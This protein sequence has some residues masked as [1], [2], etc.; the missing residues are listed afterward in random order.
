[1][2]MGEFSTDSQSVCEL[3]ILQ[4][5]EELEQK[6]QTKENLRPKDF[7]PLLLLPLHVDKKYLD[8]PF[9]ND[10][11]TFRYLNSNKS[12]VLF[13]MRGIPGS[14]KSTIVNLIKA[15]FE[16][17]NLVVCSAD[18]FF[19]K[20]DGSYTFNERLLSAAH[21]SCQQKA[22][23]ACE[24]NTPVVV[25]DNT[26]IRGW[27]MRFYLN[28]STTFGYVTVLVQ[29]KTPW[30]MDPVELAA[31]NSHSV[32]LEAIQRKVKSFEDVVPS[33][34]AWFCNEEKSMS[35]LRLSSQLLR[36]CLRA[37]PEFG[38]ELLDTLGIRGR[39][40]DDDTIGMLGKFY[41]RHERCSPLLHCTAKFCARGKVAGSSDYHQ[42]GD[43]KSSC[44]R[45]FSIAVP[46]LVFTRR[47]MGA[48][49]TLGEETASLFCKPEEKKW[50]SPGKSAGFSGASNSP[51]SKK[52]SGFSPGGASGSSQLSKKKAKKATK[53]E[54]KAK[55]MSKKSRDWGWD[56]DND[57]ENGDEVRN[58]ETEGVG[59]E[60]FNQMSENGSTT[61]SKGNPDGSSPSS[62]DNS[63][64]DSLLGKLV[65]NSIASR[66]ECGG[67][68]AK[69]GQLSESSARGC[70]LSELFPSLVYE[71]ANRSAHITL[72][73]AHGVES[74]EVNF[75]L[76]RTCD[77]EQELVKSGK[78]V[79]FVPVSHGHACYHGDG[80]CC[81]YF[82]KPLVLRT[83]FSGQY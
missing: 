54:K 78:P 75:D 17:S 28:L 29:P 24:A 71:R 26:N 5:S 19:I 20:E 79:K 36:E 72:R 58:K 39:S 38:Q 66:E 65:L 23:N 67:E 18:D 64:S 11:K 59:H 55:R 27:E 12:R 21:A 13:I 63:L 47:T 70:N 51:I 34:Y 48:R 3:V 83:V 62:I 33:Y 76:L 46:G 22:K 10:L 25:I 74:R 35:L 50:G 30:S 8:F 80:I 52:S 2:S 56:S 53:A 15:S 77:I 40:L 32:P 7:S 9:F 60:D 14:G 16:P 6:Q 73:T 37:F 69:T 45:V 44:G 1:M 31:K 82:D 57:D 41:T 43:V 61:S 49:V 42:R 68:E 4:P 81:V